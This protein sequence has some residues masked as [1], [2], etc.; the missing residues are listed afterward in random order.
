MRCLT[1]ATF[2]LCLGGGNTLDLA[3]EILLGRTSQYLRNA[4]PSGGRV[5]LCAKQ[6]FVSWHRSTGGPKVSR[7]FLTL[8][9]PQK[10][11]SP[12]LLPAVGCSGNALPTWHCK[13]ADVLWI[14]QGGSLDGITGQG[15]SLGGNLQP[16]YE[17]GNGGWLTCSQGNNL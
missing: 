7:C 11:P 5:V 15:Y 10:G 12:F 6:C 17:G 2:F 14:L 4:P 16:T 9:M 8:S 13:K 1:F 3:E